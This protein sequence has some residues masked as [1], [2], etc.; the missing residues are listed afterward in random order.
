MPRFRS[1][2]LPFF[3]L[4]RFL[5]SFA[6]PLMSNLPPETERTEKHR[7][8]PESPRLSNSMWQTAPPV[9]NRQAPWQFRMSTLFL[10]VSIGGPL[11]AMALRLPSDFYWMILQLIGVAA[12]GCVSALAI[13]LLRPAWA[14]SM[15]LVAGIGVL[16]TLV[17]IKTNRFQLGSDALQTLF[18]LATGSLITIGIGFVL[19]LSRYDR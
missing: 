4:L 11:L 18:L 12:T 1:S 17:A 6:A 5:F 19:S 10:L 3:R 13:S 15:L 16:M 14:F 7:V 8:R 2:V 9:P